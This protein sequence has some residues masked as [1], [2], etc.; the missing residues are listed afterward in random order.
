MNLTGAGPSKANFNMLK[1]EVVETD[2]LSNFMLACSGEGTSDGR[3]KRQDT[4]KVPINRQRPLTSHSTS[5]I[6]KTF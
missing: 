1:D 6:K 3:H 4:Q 2:E 5:S